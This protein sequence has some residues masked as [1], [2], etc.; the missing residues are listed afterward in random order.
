MIGCAKSV[1]EWLGEYSFTRN[2]KI[3]GN[4]TV[5]IGYRVFWLLAWAPIAVFLI[6]MGRHYKVSNR[7]ESTNS[8]TIRWSITTNY[9]GENFNGN[10]VR[11]HE[12]S[13]YNRQWDNVDFVFESPDEVQIMTNVVI[14]P[15][16]T[17]SICPNNPYIDDVICDHNNNTCDNGE[18]T[19]TGVQTGE[20]V[21]A[22]FPRKD[23]KGI[24]RNVSTCQI[25]GIII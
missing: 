25:R 24:W 20:C 13:L 7:V 3:K 18:V 5:G 16:Q 19:Y 22:D 10:Y 4:P 15:N 8:L 17:Q 1:Y 12:W 21:A 23:E 14:T 6:A 11:P 9:S 2:N